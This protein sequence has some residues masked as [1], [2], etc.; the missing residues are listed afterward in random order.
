MSR[1]RQLIE[2]LEE[3][4][5]RNEYWGLGGAGMMFVCMEDNT[6]LLGKRAN[7]V[8]QPGTW[9]IFGGGISDGWHRTPL[10]KDVALPDSSPVFLKSA[11][12][13]AKEECGSLP[14]SYKIIKTTMYEDCGF[15]YKTFVAD[16]PLSVKEKWKPKAGDGETTEFEWFDLGGARKGNLG[17]GKKMHFGPEFTFSQWRG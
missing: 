6:V 11:K 8:D 1:L 5:K 9:G 16:V 4:C 7:W 2:R 12:K 10:P 15:K 17:S 14:P 3:A 13:E